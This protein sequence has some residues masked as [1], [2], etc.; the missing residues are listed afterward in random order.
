M[1]RLRLLWS[2]ALLL[3][4]GLL[5]LACGKVAS[6]GKLGIAVTGTVAAPT[7]PPHFSIG[8]VVQIDATWHIRLMSRSPTSHRHP[9][10][11]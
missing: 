4:A 2:L 7:P 6:P 10:R 1:P 9:I 3:L 5:I 8:Q 11:P